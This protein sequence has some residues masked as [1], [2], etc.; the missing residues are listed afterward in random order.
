MN[1]FKITP[2]KFL[3]PILIFG[4]TSIISN[5][6][7]IKGKVTDVNTGESLIGAAVRLEGT[8]YVAYVKLDGTFSFVKVA[9]S[10]YNAIIT[11]TGYNKETSTTPITVANGETKEIDFT[12]LSEST[13]LKTVTITSGNGKGEK[14]ARQLEKVSNT[15]L[16][17]LSAK[18]IQLMPDITVANSLQRVSGVTVEKNSSGEA[19]YPI[20]RG[21]EKRYINTLVNG[22][23]IP[24]P[25]NKSR[26]IPLDLF[27]SEL[28]ERL[29]VSKSLT[30]S[31]EGDAIGGTINLVMKD[32]PEKKLFN[33]NYSGGYNTIF[34]NQDFF[35]FDKSSMNNHSPAEI[36]GATYVAKD[37]D[38]STNNLKYRKDPLPMNST[39]GVTYGDRFGKSKKLGIIVSGSYQNQYKGTNSSVFATSTS[40]NLD[41]KPAFETLMARQYSLNSQRLGVTAK[42][43]YKFND[44]NKISLFST[45]VKL[46]DY[47]VRRSTDST[48]AINQLLSYSSRSNLQ[49]QSIYNTTLQGVHKISPTFK[50]DWSGVYSIAKSDIPEQTSYSHGGLTINVNPTTGGVQL[51]G[52]D[53]LSGMSKSWTRNSDKDLS[54]Y[55]NLTKSLVLFGDEF[56]IKAGGLYRNKNRDNFY[57]SYS[58]NPLLTNAGTPQLFTTIENAV[59]TLKGLAATPQLNGNNYTFTEN[60][61]DGYIEGKLQLSKKLEVLGGVRLEN[62]KQ[63]YNTELPLTTASKYGTISYTDV[64]PSAQFKLQLNQDQAFRLSYYKANAR[65]QFAELIPE[66]PDNFDLFKQIGNPEGLKHTTA[67]N[68]D[69][70]YEFFPGNANQILLGTFY[71]SIQDP[72]ELSVVRVGYNTQYFQPINIGTAKNYGLEAVVTRYVGSFGVSANYTY[73]HSRVTN[74]NMLYKYYDPILRTTEK[75]VSE[76]RPLQGQA[77]HIGNL[78]LLYKNPQIGLDIQVAGV[79]TGERLSLL[80]PYAG[81]HQWIQPTTQLDISF[82][83]RIANK[84]TFYGKLNNIT[85]TPTVTAIHQ[86]YTDYLTINGIR[87]ISDQTDPNNKII[88]QK[89]YYGSSFLLGFRYKL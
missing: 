2:L 80:N 47:Q 9:P 30:P 8:K 60:V 62:T 39:L 51:T 75:T 16:N 76:T 69:L 23:K 6:Q 11:Y 21:M 78:S 38:F 85:N 61:L 29:E 89:D 14:G 70:R 77:D 25:D 64:L 15:L 87:H 56:E 46:D 24:S 82:E 1:L 63:K 28:L 58:L 10:T 36:N 35:G 49:K 22:V 34:Q 81:L 84:I 20:I 57:N 12:M 17:V 19:R 44:K 13:E 59:F 41:N 65:P 37:N 42:M 31:M 4:L 55:L 53:I 68:Y 67:D 71:K 88:V 26:F 43:D 72:I 3:I 45:Y 73:T 50:V 66:G 5:A 18:E 83:K 32:A 33:V 74:D 79:Y 40:P 48:A 27:P 7:T 54:G 52:V 86:S